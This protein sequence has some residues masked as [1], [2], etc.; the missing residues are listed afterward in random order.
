[1]KTNLIE[2]VARPVLEIETKSTVTTNVFVKFRNTGGVMILGMELMGERDF[3]Q[4]TG[5]EQN[6][7]L[8]FF[9]I[10]LAFALLAIA[11]FVIS[12]SRIYMFYGLYVLLIGIS[13]HASVGNLYNASDFKLDFFNG[14]SSFRF[15]GTLGLV[16]NV[17]FLRELFGTTRRD[18][19][20][21]RFTQVILVLCFFV[22]AITVL[23]WGFIYYP[24][25]AVLN[26]YMLFIVTA[27]VSVYYNFKRR[28]NTVRL[29]LASFSFIFLFLIIR[30]LSEQNFI[31]T[32]I[33]FSYYALPAVVAEFFVLLVGLSSLFFKKI[34]ERNEFEAAIITTQISTQESERKQIAMDLHDDLGSTL[35]I[36][37]EK[38]TTELPT[39]SASKELIIKA[40]SDL[41]SISHNLIP[42]DFE[43]FGLVKS[44]ENY[45]SQLNENG[46]KVTLITYG[47]THELPTETE[48]NLYRILSEILHNIKKHSLSKEATVQLIYHKNL[49]H[50]SV[51][52]NTGEISK[53]KNVGIGEKAVHSRL[54][55][56]KANILEKGTGENGYS[57]IFE[58]PY[59]QNPHRR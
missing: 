21:H 25:S 27:I 51:E 49:L 48:L 24:L 43:V 42:T 2:H 57:Y 58:I 31:G 34:K 7:Y 59:D 30:V 47:E 26:P 28:L 20:Y 6:V 3:F 39:N 11:F 32:P 38:V 29:Y 52:T 46:L 10:I 53:N 45:I 33:H 36:L 17:Y 23:D 13:I 18:R 15:Y 56:L 1:M 8:L 9:G 19:F 12:K 22:L 41:R 54:E 44:L 37:K 16:F 40:I 14:D 50:V 35:S 55:Y 5:F 4:K